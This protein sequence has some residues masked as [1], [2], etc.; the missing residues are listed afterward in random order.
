MLASTAGPVL[1]PDRWTAQEEQRFL[2]AFRCAP[3]GLDELR[4]MS[5]APGWKR[6]RRIEGWSRS[7]FSARLPAIVLVALIALAAVVRP[8]APF[9]FVGVLLAY[10]LSRRFGTRSTALA[11]VLPA[12][13][14]LVW[15]SLPQPPAD[16][17]GLDCANLLAPPAVWRLLEAV[18]GLIAI[19]ALVID[20]RA[21]FGELGF[22][23]GSRRVR[24]I[25]LIGLLVGTPIA[26]Y[27]G[28]V[29]GDGS[30]GGTLF[31]AYS[32]DLSQPLAILP[33]LVFAAS[34]ALAEELAYR[35]AMRVWLTPA[36]GIVGANLAQAIVFGLA[37]TGE[38]FVS[39]EGVIPT[40]LAMTV[41]GFI[42]G[43]I[44]RRTGSLTLLLA[45]HAAADIPIYLYWACRLG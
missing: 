13:A 36:L 6:P 42:G 2:R 33:A 3:V 30:V 14:I 25:A 23:R 41:V 27:A 10:L 24:T 37:H 8:A 17:A 28:T 32:L 31:G 34:N 21:S 35:G 19:V 38:G 20:R 9:V 16:L 4:R 29:V 12:A 26:I 5:A 44:A 39:L 22:R 40:M 15:R 11:A 1:A 45:F 7:S 43:V 18:V